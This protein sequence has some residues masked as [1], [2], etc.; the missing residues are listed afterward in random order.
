[1]S[2]KKTILYVDDES[3][4]V[5]VVSAVLKA[6]GY[7]VLTAGSGAEAIEI[8]KNSGNDV[9]LAI[10]DLLMPQMNG[11]ELAA[12]LRGLR[13]GLGSLLKNCGHRR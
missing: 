7:R 4:I 5:L 2:E 6:R 10:I 9:D 11:C 8:W 3:G 13:P 12:F 1:M